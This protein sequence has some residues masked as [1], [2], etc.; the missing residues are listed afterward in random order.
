MAITHAASF[1]LLAAFPAVL[2]ASQP[3][4][5]GFI[6]VPEPTDLLLFAMGFTGL[7]V[8]HRAA[9]KRKDKD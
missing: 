9:T 7:I 8:G 6:T 3:A 2:L 5:H 4:S 1:A